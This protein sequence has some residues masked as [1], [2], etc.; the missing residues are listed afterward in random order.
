MTVRV[1]K[2]EFNIRENSLN[3]KDLLEL[4]VIKLL[5]QKLF[6]KQEI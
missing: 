6:R 2:S 1:N 3:L 5:Q 4:K